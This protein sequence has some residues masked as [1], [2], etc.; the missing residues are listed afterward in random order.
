M[1]T[2]IN[3]K[4]DLTTDITDFTDIQTKIYSNGFKPWFIPAV[5]SAV[6]NQL[7]FFLIHQVSS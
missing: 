2:D 4:I 7:P 1:T 3:T 5:L 6:V